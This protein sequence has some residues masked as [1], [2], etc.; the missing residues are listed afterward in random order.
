MVRDDFAIMILSHGRADNVRTVNTLKE[1]NY[2]GKWYIII[3]DEDNQRDEYIKNFGKEHIIIFNKEEAGKTFDIMD[4]FSGRGVPTFAR[5][6]FHRIAKEL[7]LTYFLELE[8]DYMCFRQRY[9]EN[10]SMKTRYV[11]QFDLLIEPYLEFLDLSGAMCVAFAQTGDFLG[12][13]GSTVWTQ[14]IT[15]KAMNSFFCR[16][17]R[18]FQFLGRFNDDVNAYVDYGKR[19]YLFFTTRDMCLDQPQ[20]QANAG[21]I[22]EAYLQ[23]GTYVKSFYS[24]MLCPSCVKISEMGQSHKRIHHLIDWEVAV[25]KIISSKFRK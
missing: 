13:L 23:Y 20:T 4:N 12:G 17:D 16:V 6:V 19:G 21:G 14:Q 10:D 18:P 5:N 2:T 15:R 9:E 1:V 3:D 25:P 11:S 22:T 24:V 7:G 8:D